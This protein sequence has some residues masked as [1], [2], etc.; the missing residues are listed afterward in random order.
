[1]QIIAAIIMKSKKPARSAGET[2]LMRPFVFAVV[3]AVLSIPSF[4]QYTP[5][6]EVFGGFSYL[7][8]EAVSINL[9]NGSVTE[10]CTSGPGFNLCQFPPAPT[11][12]FTPRLGLYGW[13]GSV[14]ADLTPWFGFTTD[15]SGSYGN[16]T[17]SITT[18]LTTTISPC[19]LAC[20]TTE[21]YQ[22]SV[23]EPR[24][25]TFL[26][27]PQFIFPAGK[28]KAYSH[29]LAGGMN[30]KVTATDGIPS[31]S[32]TLFIFPSAPTSSTNSFAMAFGG[33]VDYP[34]RKRVSWRVGA[35]YLTSTGTAQNHVRVVTGLVWKFGK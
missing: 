6:A 35:D 7:N 14:T 3:L 13:N 23:S 15:F 2:R 30:R 29:F 27:G 32:S 12:N 25:H 24:V 10:T 19:T 5:K 26:F 9:P 4:A 31:I 34:V 22:Y 16:A 18:T 11:V 33:G 28:V 20:T 8:Y 21:D 1:L 17:D